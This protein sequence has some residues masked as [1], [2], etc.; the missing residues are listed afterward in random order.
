ME[1]KGIVAKLYES[2]NLTKNES[3]ILFEQIVKGNISTALLT[4]ILT[5]LKLKK[6]TSDEIAG[7]SEGL[8]SSAKYFPKIKYDFADIVGTGGDGLNSINI[9][10][11]SA[12]VAASCGFKIAK[13][14]N[15][16]ISSKSGSSDLLESLGI[17]LNMLPEDT[18][19]N[20]DNFNLGFL[21]APNYN[22]GM[23]HAKEARLI[24][25]TKT[26]FNILGPL[27][28][29]ARPPLMLLGVYSKDLLLPIAKTLQ[30]L[31]VKRAFVV[32][33]SGADEVAIH[34]P[35][36]VAEL[37][38][39]KISQ[40]TLNTEDFGI[41]TFSLKDIEG[42]TPQENKMIIENILKGNG[43]KAQNSAIAVNVALVMKLFGNENIK[44]N[45]QKALEVIRL[46]KPF[47]LLN[48]IIA[49]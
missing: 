22:D 41:N 10:T 44:E 39:N 18:K 31:D 12:F 11:A 46:G 43:T 37:Q 14:G 34:G 28:S 26:I 5:A 23:I 45:V 2:E 24:M 9:S 36:F 27:I 21:F 17:N 42:G 3:R 1:I 6:E 8:L 16:S 7:A 15:R 32:H 25:K 35:T 4:S 20:I 19:N 40:Y 38:N 47:E 49:N 13:H 33:G 30:K 29:P 48:N